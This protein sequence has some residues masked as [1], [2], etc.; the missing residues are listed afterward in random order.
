MKNYAVERNF[1]ITPSDGSSGPEL[2]LEQREFDGAPLYHLQSSETN[3]AIIY[4]DLEQISALRA[5]FGDILANTEYV[6]DDLVEN[7]GQVLLSRETTRD[8]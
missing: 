5:V 3:D 8:S 1:R 7:A 2:T 6:D 4:L